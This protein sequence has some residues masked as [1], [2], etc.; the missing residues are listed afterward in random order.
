M[1]LRKAVGCH[2][3]VLKDLGDI[4]NVWAFVNWAFTLESSAVTNSIL[5]SY[6]VLQYAHYL[7]NL[8]ASLNSC[9]GS[10]E[11][12]SNNHEPSVTIPASSNCA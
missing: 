6:N 5:S 8:L 11:F 7:L 9:K 10:I 1:L 2:S 3:I 4:C 12:V